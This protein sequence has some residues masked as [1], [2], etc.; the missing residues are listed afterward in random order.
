[1][2]FKIERNKKQLICSQT[3]NKNTRLNA[4]ANR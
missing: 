1:M 4:Y 3:M 2:N